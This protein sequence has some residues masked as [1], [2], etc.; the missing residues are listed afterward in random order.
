M[1]RILRA[2]AAAGTT[3]VPLFFL[4]GA[5][6]NIDSIEVSMDFLVG[7]FCG[8]AFLWIMGAL[9]ALVLLIPLIP[10]ADRVSARISLP[11]FLIVGFSV[12]ALLA[13]QALR[14]GVHGNLPPLATE[15]WSK[16]AITIAS[17]G[18]IGSGSALAAWLSVRKTQRDKSPRSLDSQNA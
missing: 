12:P 17:T 7:V 3:L 5:A 11:V 14:I 4:I 15:H 6:R 13:H 1:V 8:S 9:F 10:I 18:L 16:L 2:S